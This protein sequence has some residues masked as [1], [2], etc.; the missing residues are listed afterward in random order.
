MVEIATFEGPLPPER[1]RWVADLYGRADAKFRRTD[2]LEH[3]YTQSPAGAGLHAFVLDAGRAVGH[4]SVVPL[5]ARLGGEP[6][7]SGKLEALFVEKPYRVARLGGEWTI[8]ALLARLYALADESGIAVVHAYATPRIGR[9]IG[10]DRLEGV[11]ARSLSAVVTPRD[12]VERVLAAGQRLAQS[13]GGR[14]RGALREATTSDADLA[15]AP[16]PPDGR[17]TSLAADAW[18]WYRASPLVRVLELRDSR[19]LVQLPGKPLEALRLVGWAPERRG[20]PPALALLAALGRLGRREG[21]GTIRF[22]PWASPAANGELRRA[23][24]LL[25]FVAR[26]ELT[27]LWVR[28]RDPALARADAVVSTP[29]FTLGF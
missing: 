16:A 25:G 5:P 27:T 24:R 15:A 29:L 4:A 19:A 10:F 7:R 3:L 8:R 21:A 2:V 12:Q 18:D 1:L 20:L 22:Q 9:V 28:S 14:E 13:A 11:G 6:L 26:P 17:W 23:C